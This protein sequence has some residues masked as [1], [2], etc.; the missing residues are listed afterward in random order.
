MT[1]KIRHA[2]DSSC[3]EDHD[4]SVKRGGLTKELKEYCKALFAKGYSPQNI[5]SSMVNETDP[6]RKYRFADGSFPSQEQIAMYKTNYQRESEYER[7]TVAL[8]RKLCEGM[9]AVPEDEDTPYVLSYYIH[10]SSD[11]NIV[12]ST[13]RLLKLFSVTVRRNVDGTYK[14]LKSGHPVLIMGVDDANRTYHPSIMSLSANEKGQ[15][16]RLHGPCMHLKLAGPFRSVP[17]GISICLS[18]IEFSS[19]S[20]SLSTYCSH[21]DRPFNSWLRPRRKLPRL[22][23]R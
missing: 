20:V 8:M 12:M 7:N 4:Y 2:H 10:S 1:V 15:Y 19:F 14:L 17:L 21:Q 5:L 18:P 9:S 22:C 23:Q 11:F 3:K 13:K 16:R 6:D